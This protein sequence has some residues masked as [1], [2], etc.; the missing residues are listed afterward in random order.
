MEFKGTLI[1]VGGNENKGIGLKESECLDFIKQGILSVIVRESGGI[2]ARIVVI[3]TA[4]SI[5]VEVGENYSQAFETLGC[6]TVQI[7]DVRKRSEAQLKKNVKLIEEADCIMFS[8][9]DQSRIVKCFADTT[10]HQIIRK[11]L[12]ETKL[13][14]AGTS[15]GA[16]SMSLQM[17]AGGSVVDAMQKGNVKMARG[18]AYLDQVII[19]THFIQRG[20]FGR[21]AEAVARFPNQLGIGLA[22]DTGLVIKKGNDCEVIGTGMV[23]LFDPRN[24]NHNR[25]IDL[26]PGT[27]MSLSNLTTHVLANGDRFRIRERS[28]KILPLEASF[29]INS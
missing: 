1:P 22:E 28:L 24:L 19:D 16:M 15:A 14:L 7:V 11:K 5:P 13:V 3:T 20:R 17:I 12:E 29:T 18:M 23:V 8:G 10:A 21:L 27:P 4:S 9:G 25:Y 2:G 26:E 6:Q